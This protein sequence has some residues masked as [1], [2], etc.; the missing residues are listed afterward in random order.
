M[1]LFGSQALPGRAA[2]MPVATAHAVFTVRPI[3]PP[4]PNGLH[5]AVGYAGGH[6]PNPT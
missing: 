3:A 6:T 5:T 4:F 2:P 1:V